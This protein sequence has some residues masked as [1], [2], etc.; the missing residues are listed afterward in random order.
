MS[1]SSFFLVFFFSVQRCATPDEPSFGKVA[2]RSENNYSFGDTVQYK[3]NYQFSLRGHKTTRCQIYGNWSNP[4]PECISKLTYFDYIYS[5]V[6]TDGQQ[7]W[8]SL[9][10]W[11]SCPTTCNNM[12][13]GV[14]RTQHVTFKNV[15]SICT[16]PLFS[17]HFW[18]KGSKIKALL[19]G[20]AQKFWFLINTH[21][22][23]Y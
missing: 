21:F 2:F 6:Q 10:P 19:C 5:Y 8:E 3:C 9:G 17:W 11:F 20:Q 16:G 18:V 12:Q 14:Q 4:V 1:F 23:L 15:G 13:P 7:C 22:K